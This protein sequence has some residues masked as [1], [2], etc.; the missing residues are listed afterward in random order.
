MPR[1]ARSAARKLQPNRADLTRPTSMAAQGQPYGVAAQQRA[2]QQQIPMGPPPVGGGGPVGPPGQAPAAPPQMQDVLAAAA[3]HNGPG[4]AP[5][6]RPT[7]RPNEP[8]TSGLP[9]GPGPG[10]E[11]LQGVGAAAREMLF[12]RAHS[13]TCSPTWPLLLARQPQ[14]E[15]SRP[16]LLVV[17]S[18]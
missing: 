9:A 4:N 18:E 16:A 6:T 5:F 13:A 14:S 2:A 12:S 11:S 17:F 15:T 8:V 3:A 10:P 1:A 7:E